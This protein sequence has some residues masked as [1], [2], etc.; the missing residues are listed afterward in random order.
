MA[1]DLISNIV[2]QDCVSW[3]GTEL[4][5]CWAGNQSSYIAE[6]FTLDS[7][8][9]N[10]FLQSETTSDSSFYPQKSHGVLGY[11]VNGC[12]ERRWKVQ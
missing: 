3:K 8:D 11:L 7:I 12:E 5:S 1:I 6:G 9:Y 10:R 4:P 2:N